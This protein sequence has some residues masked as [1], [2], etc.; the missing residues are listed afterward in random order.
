[1]EE[2]NGSSW[3]VVIAG[4]GI[5]Q[6]LLALAL[7]RSNKKILHLDKNDYYGQSEVALSIQDA[8]RWAENV[9]KDD[10]RSPF[11]NAS[12]RKPSDE[13]EA[14]KL[15]SF[16]GYNLA[17]APSLLYTRTKLLPALV[18][19]H[20]HEQ[21]DF[22][23]VGSWFVYQKTPDDEPPGQSV[24]HGASWFSGKLG[25]VP[26][27]RE[28]IFADPSLSLKAKGALVKFLRFVANYEE[29][30]EEWEPQ[31][32]MPFPD[33]L[34]SKFKIA[35]DFHG[36]LLALTMSTLP[37]QQTSTGFAIAR[38][39]NHLRSIG[40][41]GPG[42]SAVLAKWGGLSEITQVACRAGAVNGATY[43]LNKSIE[44][45]EDAMSEGGRK[46]TVQLDGG[47]TVSADIIVGS[48]DQFP[49]GISGAT[50]PSA[51]SPESQPLVVSRSISII[52]STLPSLFPVTAE[53]GSTPGG[54]VIFFP[55]ES[56]AKAG[57]SSTSNALPVYLLVH[58]CDTGECP[59]GQSVIYASTAQSLDKAGPVLEAA[60]NQLVASTGEQPKPAVLWTLTYEQSN[61]A[62]V[63]QIT[64]DPSRPNV[65]CFQG[66]SLDT[67][68]DEAILTSVRDAWQKITGDVPSEFLKLADR[69]DEPAEED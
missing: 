40:L 18:S 41:F 39:A 56:L 51:T 32:D 36:P 12:I 38:I 35:A 22:Q 14:P 43:V 62:A 48:E 42:F 21:I 50:T 59:K 31:K 37:P 30:T 19:S 5:Q 34:S 61:K 47:D 16:R 58:S 55:A 11:Q 13:S 66:P 17:L 60:V 10:S 64:S 69:N 68:F 44:S 23:A 15:T 2:L 4:T 46:L 28:D 45:I 33:F 54:A 3:D 20:V 53:G 24:V 29:K 6:S 7:S 26:N 67:V 1:M 63:A 25:R 65:M 49:S 27:S 52:S 8:E 57:E 9:N